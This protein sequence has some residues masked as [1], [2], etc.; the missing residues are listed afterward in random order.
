M[1]LQLSLF[2]QGCV[3][4]RCMAKH[5]LGRLSLV[6]RNPCDTTAHIHCIGSCSVVC[7]CALS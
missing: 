1:I 5:Q 4:M 2:V 3:D 7:H 6:Q